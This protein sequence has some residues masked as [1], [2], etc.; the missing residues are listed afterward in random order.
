MSDHNK[1]LVFPQLNFHCNLLSRWQAKLVPNCTK[2]GLQTHLPIRKFGRETSNSCGFPYLWR[3]SCRYSP[4]MCFD[5]FRAPRQRN[6]L[7]SCPDNPRGSYTSP[8]LKWSLWSWWRRWCWL[9]IMLVTFQCVS[10]FCCEGGD[11]KKE[12]GRK[13]V[14]PDNE[15]LLKVSQ[16]RVHS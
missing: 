9:L 6:I 16:A 12:E 14:S 2:P 7:C 10:S 11:E 8:R 3:E 5:V 15:T 4:Q 1:T 13:H